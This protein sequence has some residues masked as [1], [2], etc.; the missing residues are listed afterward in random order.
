MAR[1][2]YVLKICYAVVISVITLP[3][4]L[5]RDDAMREREREREDSAY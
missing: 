5:M 1:I 3:R 2:N 4:Q